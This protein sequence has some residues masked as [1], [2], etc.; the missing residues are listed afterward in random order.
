M[1]IRYPSTFH[2][3]IKPSETLTELDI[4][5]KVK[6]IGILVKK[7]HNKSHFIIDVNALIYNIEMKT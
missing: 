4:Y 6:Y 7:S 1:L 5:M 2:Q 3:Q